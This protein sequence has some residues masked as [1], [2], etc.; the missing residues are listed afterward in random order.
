MQDPALIE[1]IPFHSIL[2]DVVLD[3]SLYTHADKDASSRYKKL[4]DKGSM[5]N[6]GIRAALL[7]KSN[8]A[9]FIRTEER[10]AYIA[11]LGDNFESI[12]AQNDAPLEKKA[13][14]LYQSAATMME[15]IFAQPMA[16]NNLKKSQAV[17][18]GTIKMVMGDENALLALIQA[19]DH[20][21]TLFTHSMDVAI[22]A[23]GLGHFMGLDE[24]RLG[25]LG[26]AA[27]MHDIGKVKIPPK[28]IDKPGPLDAYEFDM[29]KMH[30][31]YS[32]NIVKQF[33]QRDPEIL[34]GIKYHHE[35][36]DGTGYPDRL[37]GDEIP[38]F[39]KILAIC[40]G[41]GAISTRTC[42][43][44][45]HSSFEALSI[46][47]KEMAGAYDPQL[48]QM[49]IRFLGSLLVEKKPKKSE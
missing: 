36:I 33:G 9:L 4:V 11:Y 31:H 18:A 49:F 40:D 21:Y 7:Y 8:D 29:V 22:Y 27:L 37:T 23:I 14:F 43:H 26:F 28:V 1:P 10:P 48:L 6:S 12:Q 46:M 3:F 45:A 5:L 19:S 44:E 25:K 2:S 39:G 38:L 24:E 17:V 16:S 30:S 42:Y 20:H 34:E 13:A 35:R 15:S 32:Y 41:Y 47:K